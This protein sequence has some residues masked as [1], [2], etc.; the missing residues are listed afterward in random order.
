VVEWRK[1]GRRWRQEASEFE[2]VI[3]VNAQ[4]AAEIK[5]RMLDVIPDA[6]QLTAELKQ[7]VGVLQA[8]TGTSTSPALAC[9]KLTRGCCLC[10]NRR[11]QCFGT[12]WECLHRWVALVRDDPT[13]GEVLRRVARAVVQQLQGRLWWSSTMRM[14]QKQKANLDH[15]PRFGMRFALETQL[16]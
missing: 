8:C 13:M 12:W 4:A 1:H 15:Q 2:E 11:K 3:R 5:E 10:C 7:P 6:K 16:S 9:S 14:H